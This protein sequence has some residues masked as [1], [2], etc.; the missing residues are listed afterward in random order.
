M[1]VLRLELEKFKSSALSWWAQE[2]HLPWHAV[3]RSPVTSLMCLE[4]LGCITAWG[5]V[6]GSHSASH[7]A[8][9][10]ATDAALFS[11]LFCKNPYKS[12][13]CYQASKYRSSF[14]KAV[15]SNH[16]LDTR[17][18]VLPEIGKTRLTLLFLT[19]L[20]SASHFHHWPWFYEQIF[21][22]LSSLPCIWS[23]SK[24]SHWVTPWKCK[25]IQNRFRHSISWPTE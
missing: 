10:M 1:L 8:K 9:S 15:F 17:G 22:E 3:G 12:V 18:D 20:L 6:E 21:S 19:F 23:C 2:V 25:R 5:D 4:G 24:I 16:H 14:K 7:Q 13:G 11:L